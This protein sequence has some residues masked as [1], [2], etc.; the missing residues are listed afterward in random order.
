M[1]STIDFLYQTDIRAKGRKLSARVLLGNRTL[2]SAASRKKAAL[3]FLQPQF[4]EA[5]IQ[6]DQKF[7]EGPHT[8]LVQVL[9]AREVNIH[10]TRKRL[11]IFGLAISA[12]HFLA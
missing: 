10:F 8:R 1:L 4:R 6:T 3:P 9:Q 5:T 11:L 7:R 2:G 12:R